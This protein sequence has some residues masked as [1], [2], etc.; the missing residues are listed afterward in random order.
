MTDTDFDFDFDVSGG[1]PSKKADERPQDG[2]GRRPGSRF[3]YSA[4]M[5]NCTCA[6]RN[7]FNS[8]RGAMRGRTG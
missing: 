7:G 4:A 8:S 3:K 1:K 6:M 5:S 2:N